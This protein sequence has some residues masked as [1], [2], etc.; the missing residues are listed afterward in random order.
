[1]LTKLR[2]LWPD[3][4]HNY[5]ILDEAGRAALILRGY[6]GLL[7]LRALQTELAQGQYATLEAFTLAYDQLHEHDCF[8]V[9]LLSDDPPIEL[10]RA[11]VEWC[12]QARLTTNVGQSETARSFARSAARYYAYLRCRRFL[13]FST[14]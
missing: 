12:A 8:D 13:D 14:S 9:E 11:E 4:Y 6:N 3:V 5:D 2:E 10:G 1:C 7:G